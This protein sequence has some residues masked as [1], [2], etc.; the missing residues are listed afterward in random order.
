MGLTN[1][2]IQLR[3][4]RLPALE[5]VEVDALAD[6]DSVHLY[7]P[8]H[9]QIQLGLEAIDQKVVTLADG[10]EKIVPYVGPI[11]LRFKN[12]IGF[13]GALVIGDQVLLGA[14]PMEDMDLV[15]IPKTREVMVNPSSP[16]IASSIVK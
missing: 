14:I 1:A 4:P 6:T 10:R 9:I 8:P 13:S 11:E 7:I 16:N 15:V 2:S 5:P 3:N 12:R